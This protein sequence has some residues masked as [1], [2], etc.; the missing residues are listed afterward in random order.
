MRCACFRNQVISDK[1]CNNSNRSATAA[2]AQGRASFTFLV[3]NDVGREN[4]GAFVR[5]RI[6]G[7]QVV[8]NKPCNKGNR[9]A[10]AAGAA[11]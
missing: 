9:S 7:V 1:P 11:T 5:V 6:L 10:A 3:F 4:A 2:V 8:S